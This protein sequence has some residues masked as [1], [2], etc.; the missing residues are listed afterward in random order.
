MKVLALVGSNR[1]Q[2]NTALVIKLIAEHLSQ[3]A[4]GK[5][6]PL[7]IQILNLGQ[8]HLKTCRGCRICFDKGETKCP[9]KDDLLK[10]KA[11]IQAAD[12]LLVSSP[13]YVDDVSGTV[14]NWI[15][16]MAHVCHRPEFAG[17]SAYVAATTGSSPCG[18]TLQTMNLALR[19]WGYA[20]IGQ[21][22]FKT[23]S[24][25]KKREIAS[26]YNHKIRSIAHRILAFNLRKRQLKPSFLSLMIFKIQQKAWSDKD[27][28]SY[29]YK[30]W[31]AKGWTNPRITYFIPHRVNFF[32]V[33]AA[34]L[35]GSIIVRFMV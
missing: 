26:A 16:R 12:I 20:I 11:K 4:K 13:V 21:A 17:K 25:M 5:G 3:A 7:K 22:G 15:D 30:Y 6:L 35:M 34:R 27:R 29:D 2:G 31:Q 23:G 14:K 19:V 32:K 10:I 9:W 24:L 18:R 8:M 1:K 28:D 33:I